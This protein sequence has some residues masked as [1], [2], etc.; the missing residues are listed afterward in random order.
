MPFYTQNNTQAMLWI[1]FSCLCDTGYF[2]S[3]ASCRHGNWLWFPKISS[4]LALKSQFRADF[5]LSVASCRHGNWLCFHDPYFTVLF[6]WLFRIS[7]IFMHVV[8]RCR[9]PRMIRLILWILSWHRLEC[10]YW[11]PAT[12]GKLVELLIY[13]ARLQFRCM[14][15]R[16]H[17]HEK[18]RDKYH[19]H[20]VPRVR[21]A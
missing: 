11:N 3:I 6:W 2:S 12:N 20:V 9:C 8:R 15:G 4:K 7:V 19:Q 5:R 14:S 1:P 18:Y 21:S 16:A 17:C 13:S 10:A